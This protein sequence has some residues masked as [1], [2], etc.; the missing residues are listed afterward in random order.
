MTLFGTTL[1]GPAIVAL[2]GLLLALVLLGMR[3]K[4]DRN[5]WRWFK[6]WEAERKARRDAEQARERG[7]DPASANEPPRGPWG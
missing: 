3:L 5:Y 4:G 1:D 2:V 6:Q 7:E